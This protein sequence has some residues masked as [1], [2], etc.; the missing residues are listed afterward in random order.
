MKITITA[1]FL[2]I[3]SFSANAQRF[4]GNK[5]SVKWKQVNTSAARV[6][7]PEGLDTFAQ[8]IA[9]IDER[10]NA[11]TLPTIGTSQQKINIVLQPTTIV[12][13]GYVALGPYRSEFYLTPPQNS[14]ELG[15][16]PWSDMLAM[17]EYR[18]VQQYNNF[19][20][21]LSKF[22][23]V[24]FGQQGQELANAVSV[25]NWF[26]EG[27]AVFQETLISK[28]GRGRLPFFFD[29]YRSLWKAGKNY[30][31]MKLRNGSLRDFTPD[32]YRLGYMMVAYGRE[33]YGDD[34]WK[35]VTHDAAAFKGLFYPFQ[36][37][38]RQYAGVSYQQ[39][40]TDALNYFKQQLGDAQQ[41]PVTTSKHFLAN[42]EFPVYT[43]NETVIYVKDS[44][45][46]IP[47]FIEK[48]GEHE[49]RIRVRDVSI[50][51]Q[52]SYRNGKIVYASFR[53]DY[54]WGWNDYDEV[55]V[56]DVASGRQT[57]I[58]HHTKYF[59]P[60]ISEDGKTIIA[61]DVQP[62]G[63]YQLHILDAATGEVLNRLPNPDHFLYTYP[64]FVNDKQVVSAVKNNIGQMALVL[65]NIA[66]GKS[67]LL[68]PFSFRVIGFPL[69]QHGMI[70][71]SAADKKVDKI[72][73]INLQDKKIRS[74]NTTTEGIGS[75]QP[76]VSNKNILFS[77]FT[78]YGFRL[79]QVNDAADKWEDV[80]STEWQSELP[81]P[82]VD[83]TK[84]NTASLLSTVARK[85]EAVSS[86]RKS[87]RLINFHSIRPLT[88]DPDYTISIAGE[89]VLN[90]LQSEIYFTYNT[91]ERYKRVGFNTEYAGWYPHI[92]AGVSHT[93]ERQGL[94]RGLKRFY[95]DE[96]ELKAGLNIPFNFSKGRSYTYLT[97]GSDYVY[98]QPTASGIYKDSVAAFS[99]MSS[100]ISFTN[101]SQQAKQHINPRFA[102]TLLISYRNGVTR[103]AG[104]RLL[105]NGNL[106]LP[107]FFNTHSIVLNAAY[108]ARGRNDKIN[109]S[110]SFPF[111]RGYNSVNL[112]QMYKFGANYH[113]PLLYPDAGIANTV[114]FM[115]VR[116]NAFYDYTRADDFY[117]N[118]QPFRGVF[119]SAGGEIFFDTKWW[120]QLPVSFGFRYS[121][122]LDS[123]LFGR[124]ANWFE[125]IL[126]V[127]LLQ[128]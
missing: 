74:L 95:F 60:D 83:F 35:K 26:W 102:Q 4:G 20:V 92:S 82:G 18:H 50:D 33:K 70:Y 100:Y 124:G 55:Q 97:I 98:N 38:I 46:Q 25:P 37:A 41:T 68:T 69:V 59:S 10:L 126:P 125:F 123:D 32:H 115:R 112:Y 118:G 21:G 104:A 66:D 48:K 12:S 24:V 72:F 28:Q 113:F 17:H 42:Q 15:S 122:L 67:E 110:N 65:I 86:Y 54:R 36:K 44:Y 52:F 91:D 79:Q 22:F 6:I 49:R 64:K 101:Q 75:Y 116:G 120:N 31:W 108:T 43:D 87:T 78:A 128:R 53:P 127:N 121:R 30:S 107:G 62:N 13:N 114:Y 77:T 61:A 29:D 94:S 73:S 81:T 58:T 111:S 7:F 85:P 88:D 105:L 27:D 106:Y 117:S 5:P 99:Y 93:F 119:S 45:K 9:S 57:T 34:F 56:L 39:F 71:F 1:A 90:T 103:L 8:R 89:N 47:V 14:F 84:N 23:R 16:L 63:N 19:N 76:A 2:L 51:N 11:A 109:F 80:S 3:V 40:R 96:T